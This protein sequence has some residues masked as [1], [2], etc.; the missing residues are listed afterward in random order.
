[1]L[2]KTVADIQIELDCRDLTMQKLRKKYLKEKFVNEKIV[3]D[4]KAKMN[5]SFVSGT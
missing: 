5:M 3:S 4:L 1:M 2:K